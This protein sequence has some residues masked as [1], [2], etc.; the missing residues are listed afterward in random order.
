MN[1]KKGR[2]KKPVRYVIIK[3]FISRC[4]SIHVRTAWRRSNETRYF[5]TSIQCISVYANPFIFT[6]ELV[7]GV[8]DYCSSIY[9]GFICNKLHGKVGCNDTSRNEKTFQFVCHCSS[10]LQHVVA[11][12]SCTSLGSMWQLSAQ[13]GDKRI[14]QIIPPA[15][16]VQCYSLLNLTV[17]TYML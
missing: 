5:V 12:C 13:L 9:A 2:S 10:V 17:H 7:F 15:N 1:T 6:T 16:N 3:A 4:L 8:S 14:K 11:S